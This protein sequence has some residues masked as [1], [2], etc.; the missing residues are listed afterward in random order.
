MCQ[1]V[2]VKELAELSGR[3]SCSS[4]G[5]AQQKKFHTEYSTDNCEGRDVKNTCFTL[6]QFFQSVQHHLDSQ[7]T[8]STSRWLR[9]R[10]GSRESLVIFFEDS[11]LAP[12]VLGAF[13][14]EPPVQVGNDSRPSQDPWKNS[15]QKHTTTCRQLGRT[16]P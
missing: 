2:L 4:I 9:S 7:P 5:D 16:P 15:N 6:R 10:Q 13:G 8:H 14:P 12:W 3:T 11:R 1:P